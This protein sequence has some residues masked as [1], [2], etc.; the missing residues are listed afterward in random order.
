MTF[1]GDQNAQPNPNDP[2]AVTLNADDVTITASGGA[3]GAASETVID[4]DEIELRDAK[5]AAQAEDAAKKAA[6]Q[7]E[8]AAGT[9]AQTPQPQP[10]QQA[11]AQPAAHAETPMIPK[12]R[13]DEVNSA[14]AQAE[15]EAAYWRGQA[16]ARAT[17]PA[18]ASQAQQPQQPAQPTAEQRLEHIQSQIDALAEKL[19]AG[20]I[21]MKEF[22]QHE[23][24]LT[25]AEQQIREE[26]LLARVKPAPAPQPTQSD[27]LYLETLTAQLEQQHPWVKVFDAVGTNAQWDFLK[28]QAIEN[29]STRGIDPRNGNLGRYELRKEIA[30]LADAYGPT[31]VAAQAQ[32]KGILLP[33]QNQSPQSGQ[34]QA[35]PQISPQAQARQGKLQL[36]ET[37]PPDL[38][39][40]TGQGAATGVTDAQIESMSED[41]IG[42]LPEATRRRLLGII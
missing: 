3:P 30:A 33:G 36:R 14:R 4:L 7:N 29:L 18:T 23:R 13:F 32:A 35:Q 22:K 16:E 6:P 10:Q 38:S 24:A 28:N 21:T 34:Q 5:A 19:D 2:N 31:L 41:E 15:R 12:A 9:Q 20:E 26:M 8:P 27:E 1:E 17:A 11:Q 25:S 39:N 42:A 40:L 37:A